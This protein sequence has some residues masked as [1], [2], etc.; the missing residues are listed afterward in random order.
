MSLRESAISSGAF[1]P[2]LAEIVAT[3]PSQLKELVELLPPRLIEVAEK[4]P[5]YSDRIPGAA[6]VSHRSL[7][8]WPLPWQRPYGKAITPTIALLAVAYS[9]LSAA[10]VVMSGRRAA[11]DTDDPLT[12]RPP[13]PSP[14]AGG[15]AVRRMGRRKGLGQL[16]D[17]VFPKSAPA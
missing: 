16:A 10:P 3:L 8:A 6:L 1:S 2:Q 4:A 9:K 12:S 11:R 13:N 5:V 14:A 15:S 7:E 17:N